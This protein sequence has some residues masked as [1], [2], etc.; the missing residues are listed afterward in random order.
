MPSPIGA[1]PSRPGPPLLPAA[2]ASTPAPKGCRPRP[3]APSTLPRPC[4]ST[5][6]HHRLLHDSSRTVPVGIA[7]TRP[8]RRLVVSVL[9]L[10]LSSSSLVAPFPCAT[11]LETVAGTPVVDYIDDEP[12][13]PEQ[14]D[15][16]APWSQTPPMTTPTALEVPTTTCRPPTTTRS[17][18]GGSLAG[19]LRLFRSVSQFVLAILW[20][21]V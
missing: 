6:R 11:N 20:K 18:L 15:A 12:F 5:P 17:S 9:L 7:I 3:R 16:G 2:P 8:P 21:L 14:P 4:R 10:G 19:G 13:L 1:P